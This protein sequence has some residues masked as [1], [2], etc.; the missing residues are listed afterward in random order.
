[1]NMKNEKLAAQLESTGDYKIQRRLGEI[2]VTPR[3]EKTYDAMYVDTK[4][5]EV[6]E[7]AMVPFRFTREGIITAVGEP[8][9]SYNEPTKVITPEITEI[10]GITAD[11]V[12]DHKLNV[13]KI[14]KFLEGVDVVIAHNAGFDRPMLERVSPQ[15]TK[16]NWS[17]S[18]SQIPWGRNKRLEHI[19]G[20]MGIFYKAHN[21]VTDCMA[22]LYALTQC[23]NAPKDPSERKTGM[24]H[25]I[26][27]TRKVTYHV[28]ALDAPFDVKDALKARGYFWN[29]G[30]DGRPK[31]WHKE[32][33]DAADED[34]WLRANIYK[35]QLM[36]PARFDRLTAKE[37][38]STRG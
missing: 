1:M 17:C 35:K 22:G 29:G 9:H 31:A 28:W 32:V 24:A 12:K 21:A 37:R 19:L 15:F 33:D 4:V 36:I 23:P 13:G 26:E 6:I 7:L 34:T 10:T 18:L 16:I 8:F 2:P 14:N 5:D 3:K 27:A 11:M 30:E 38:F 20:D 25:L